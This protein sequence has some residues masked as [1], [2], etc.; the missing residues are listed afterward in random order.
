MGTRLVWT[1]WHTPINPISA[2]VSYIHC[3]GLVAKHNKHTYISQVMFTIPVHI[4]VA[5]SNNPLTHVL[6]EPGK[7]ARAIG[8]LPAPFVKRQVPFRIWP[9]FSSA[10]TVLPTHLSKNIF[11]VL[12]KYSEQILDVQ[13]PSVCRRAGIVSSTPPPTLLTA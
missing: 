12:D 1:H 10:A 5:F 11:S 6:P 7:L 2:F 4:P 13:L 8:Y 9:N 3:Q